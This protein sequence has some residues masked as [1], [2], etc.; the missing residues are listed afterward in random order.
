MSPTTAFFQ[1]ELQAME[2]D[3]R[4]GDLDGDNGQENAMKSLSVRHAMLQ[5]RGSRKTWPTKK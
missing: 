4:L 1:S 5:K 2:L 3:G